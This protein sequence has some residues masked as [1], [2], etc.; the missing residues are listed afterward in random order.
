MGELAR[1]NQTPGTAIRAQRAPQPITYNEQQLE[2][3][4]QALGGGLQKPDVVFA[5]TWAKQQGLDLWSE[6]GYVWRDS[7]GLHLQVAVK[8][9]IKMMLRH[10][11][12]ISH[13]GPHFLDPDTK[14]WH[15]DDEY[16]SDKPPHMARF[17]IMSA[18]NAEPI[19]GVARW[20][21][22]GAAKAKKSADSAWATFPTRMLGGKAIGNAVKM[23]FEMLEDA[24]TISLVSEV[25]PVEG[26]VTI[27]DEATGEIVEVEG[28]PSTEK[29][30]EEQLGLDS[31]KN[32]NREPPK[33]EPPKDLFG[34]QDTTHK[35]RF[36]NF[37]ATAERKNKP[38][39]V[40]AYAQ[41]VKHLVNDMP[42]EMK[43]EMNLVFEAR[44][45]DLQQG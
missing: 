36:D 38:T 41:E 31:D 25:A 8:G 2:N 17:V 44:L 18:N 24:Q 12:Y 19:T 13:S 11:A 34:E 14:K 20:S 4:M 7:K 45:K 21:E 15:K 22:Y 29:S 39:E 1:T 30:P 33:E 37:K 35:K 10:P 40:M 43:A 23:A 6:E 27:I 16:L 42:D 32:P 5:L 9:Y 28:V 3:A 26:E